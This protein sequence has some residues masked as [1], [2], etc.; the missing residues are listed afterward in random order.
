MG[1]QEVFGNFNGVPK[2]MIIDGL[3][4]CNQSFL[5]LFFKKIAPERRLQSVAYS[6][7]SK[8]RQK[9]LGCKCLECSG[10]LCIFATK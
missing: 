1:I 3:S 2:A 7:P 8:A 4:E 6:L 5:S 9:F 10:V